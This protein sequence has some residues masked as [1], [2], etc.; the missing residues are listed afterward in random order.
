LFFDLLIVARVK[1]SFPSICLAPQEFLSISPHDG[2]GSGESVLE[3]TL[4]V[5]RIS[6]PPLGGGKL[7]LVTLFSYEKVLI[8]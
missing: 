5:G 7:V 1:D 6:A 8:V 4:Y 3:I 2:C